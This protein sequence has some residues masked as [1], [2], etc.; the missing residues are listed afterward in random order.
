MEEKNLIQ[1]ISVP[2]FEAKGWMKFLGVMYIIS[3]VISILSIV[4][5]LVCWLPI[6]MGILLFKS[7]SEVEFAQISGEKQN[8]ILSLSK[9]RTYFIINGVLMLIG[10]AFVVIVLIVSG[11]AM[12]S[13]FRS[14]M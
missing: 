2:I 11:G 3:G 5:I 10:I 12:L 6:W 9:L 13:A 1:E 14:Y 4:G 8:L 7:G